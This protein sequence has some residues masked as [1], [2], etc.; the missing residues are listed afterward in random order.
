MLYDKNA[1]ESPLLAAKVPEK[2]GQLPQEIESLNYMTQELVEMLEVLERKLSPVMDSRP[3]SVK[4]EE[5]LR[6]CLVPHAMQIRESRERVALVVKRM[7]FMI[8][9]IQV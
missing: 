6:Q 3:E 9:D 2:V 4:A 7:G 8:E 5:Q 1:N